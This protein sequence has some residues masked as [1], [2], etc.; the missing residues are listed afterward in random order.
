MRRIVSWMGIT[1]SA[2]LLAGCP[3]TMEAPLSVDAGLVGDGA[4]RPLAIVAERASDRLEMFAV[5]PSLAAAAALSVD[6]NPGAIDEPLGMALAPDGESVYLVLGHT[7][8]YAV[9]KLQRI[10]LRDGARLGEVALG[11]E[12]SM[13]A[14]DAGGARGYVSLF[15][16]LARPEGPWTAA[17]GLVVVDLAAMKVV[18]QVDVCAAALGLALDEAR[19]RVWVACLGAEGADAVAIVDV[20]GPA[21]RVDRLLP[22][23][24]NAGAAYV[25]LDGKSAFVTTQVSGELWIFDQASYARRAALPLGSGSFPQQMARTPDGAFV[26]V[27][28]DGGQEIAAV[29]TDGL[30]VVDRVP[31]RGYHPQGIAVTPDGRYAL[32]TDEGDLKAP[33]RLGRIDLRGLGAGG[34]RLEA[35]VGTRV[36]PSAIVIA[37]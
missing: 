30:L 36:F 4:P 24:P 5:A 34:A 15:R 37:P 23:A 22:L 19:G 18:G 32:F 33:G 1:A 8:D 20:T 6:E 35:T 25:L 7:A 13:I 28:V 26:L 31:L 17:G 2:V 14:I 9:G 27:A 21:P 11:E 16:N 12:P 3:G 29:A 10:R